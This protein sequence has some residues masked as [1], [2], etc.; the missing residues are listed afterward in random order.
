[1]ALEIRKDVYKDGTLCY[2]YPY[3]NGKIHGAGKEY[4]PNGNLVAEKNF[5]H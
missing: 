2:E 1:M 3:L 4:A 5:V